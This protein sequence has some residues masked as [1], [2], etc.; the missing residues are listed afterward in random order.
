MFLCQDNRPGSGA[1]RRR[2]TTLLPPKSFNTATRGKG[3]PR[4]HPPRPIYMRNT[5]NRVASIGALSAAEKASA[6]TRRVSPGAMTPSSH[7]RAVA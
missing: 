5:P 3:K 1:S 6:S 4:L 2:A 7:S